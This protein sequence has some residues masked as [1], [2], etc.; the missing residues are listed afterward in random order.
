MKL[1]HAEAVETSANLAVHPHLVKLDRVN[2][3]KPTAEWGR[4][5]GDVDIPSYTHEFAP[6]G[7]VGSLEDINEES[8]RSLLDSSIT[9]L[10]DFIKT[11]KEYQ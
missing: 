6:D 10:A 1:N 2:N 3:I 8:G 11:F 7:V 4:R 5:I 9:K